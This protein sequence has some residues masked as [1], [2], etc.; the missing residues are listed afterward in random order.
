[1]TTSKGGQAL[2][3]GEV[4]FDVE[5]DKIASLPLKPFPHIL[6]EGASRRSIELKHRRGPNDGEFRK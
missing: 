3:S 6:R 4:Y 5:L 1:M 2:A